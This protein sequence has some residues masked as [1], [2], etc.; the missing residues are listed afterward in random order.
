MKKGFTL[1][2]LLAVIILLG[3][4]GLIIY[5][6]V[7]GVINNN[8]QKL[9]DKQ[10]DE[11]V[12]HANTYS[13]EN[14]T[15]L[16]TNDGARNIVTITDLY[17]AGLIQN[18]KVIDPKTDQELTGCLSLVWKDNI[19][20]FD[21]TYTNNCLNSFNLSGMISQT[22]PLGRT[23][24]RYISTDF[25]VQLL[26]GDEIA[27]ETNTD[28]QG[29]YIF[30]GIDG[31]TYLLLISQPYKTKYV[32]KVEVTSDIEKNFENIKLYIGDFNEDGA[33]DHFDILMFGNDGCFVTDTT[34]KPECAKFDLDLNGV[35]NISDSNEIVNVNNFNKTSDL[36]YEGASKITGKILYDGIKKPI[37]VLDNMDGNS[38]NIEL[39][40]NGHFEVDN[41]PNGVYIIHTSQDI[42]TGYTYL[43]KVILLQNNTEIEVCLYAGDADNNGKINDDDLGT[44]EDYLAEAKSPTD[45]T[46][47]RYDFNDDK[48]IDNNDLNI[49]KGNLGK[50]VEFYTKN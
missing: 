40:E 13:T 39:K 4:L 6:T 42:R 29:R 1:V 31:G 25:K 48:K 37:L 17:N 14:I 10:I 19:N 18:D 38:Y 11:L 50:Y 30:N 21:I 22:D 36:L 16:K 2:E 26:Q 5:P 3:L 43:S 23:D 44:L 8:K 24:E 15:K 47:E 33:V 46:L 7:N 20:G 35:I 49:L 27:Y 28:E 9:H 41:L 12:R 32:R 45:K 34:S